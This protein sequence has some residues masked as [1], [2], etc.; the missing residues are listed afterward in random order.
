MPNNRL[1]STDVECQPDHAYNQSTKSLKVMWTEPNGNCYELQTENVSQGIY[2]SKKP[3]KTM[4]V[5]LKPACKSDLPSTTIS[6]NIGP[7]KK[8]SNSV[9]HNQME[10]NESSS[11]KG[12]NRSIPDHK[13]PMQRMNSFEFPVQSESLASI[14]DQSEEPLLDHHGDVVDG[15]V[16]EFW[17]EDAGE[18][19]NAVGTVVSADADPGF[20]HNVVNQEVIETEESKDSLLEESRSVLAL[21]EYK[22]GMDLGKQK[23]VMITG[24]FGDKQCIM[25][26]MKDPVAEIRGAGLEQSQADRNRDTQSCDIMLTVKDPVAEIRGA[27]LEAIPS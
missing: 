25:L 12:D 18:V 10:E 6:H 13:I 5:P 17:A 2:V 11:I 22:K 7:K 3:T 8:G 15:G 1:V 20:L 19:N 16:H 27:G 23:M 21:G 9:N 24:P 14:A 4:S 26:T